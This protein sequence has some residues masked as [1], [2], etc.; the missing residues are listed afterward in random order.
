MLVNAD[1]ARPAALRRFF[2]THGKVN[3]VQSRA[4]C[5]ESYAPC[6][7]VSTTNG[8]EVSCIDVPLDDIIDV[9][10][11]T[12]PRDIYSVVV[13]A[14]AA[15][16][17]PVTLPQDLLSDK[18]VQNIY[19]M[20]PSNDVQLT[21]SPDS[22]RY[23]RDTTTH[24]EIESCDITSL[25]DFGFL[26]N[27]AVLKELA[28]LNSIGVS[29]KGLPALPS[30]IDLTVSDCDGLEASA[31]DFPSLTPARV[32][33]ISLA[34]CGLTDAGASTIMSKISVSTSASSLLSVDL[35]GNELTVVPSE[36]HALAKLQSLFLMNNKIVQTKVGDLSFVSSVSDVN[37]ESNGITD[38]EGKTFEYGDFTLAKV[39]LRGNQLSLFAQNVFLEV[40]K[41]M[42]VQPPEFAGYVDVQDSKP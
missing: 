40:L 29:L 6:S 23:T 34:R 13:S 33:K 19:L 9:F 26:A 27:F 39:Q 3:G 4:F 18:R 17:D 35:S 24:F 36:V 15:P 16:A 7:C 38:M 14:S 32:A 20:C 12:T 10:Y 31:A 5:P 41:Q 8:I 2:N 21:I 22:F 11:R 25:P 30:L 37:L 1:V 28:V 42:A